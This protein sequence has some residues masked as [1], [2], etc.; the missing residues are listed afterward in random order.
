MF[1]RIIFYFFNLFTVETSFLRWAIWHHGIGILGAIFH[2]YFWIGSTWT[3]FLRSI[4][5]YNHSIWHLVFML[6]FWNRRQLFWPLRCCTICGLFF[7]MLV[8]ESPLL[9]N[10]FKFLFLWKPTFTTVWS[11]ITWTYSK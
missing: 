7:L 8:L 5:S 4:F 1:F 9:S 11:L 2:Y 3:V 6:L 10:Y